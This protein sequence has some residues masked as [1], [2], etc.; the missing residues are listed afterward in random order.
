MNDDQKPDRETARRG[1]VAASRLAAIG[2][3]SAR[4]L[5]AG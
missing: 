5:A 1:Y 4:L 2:S 3:C